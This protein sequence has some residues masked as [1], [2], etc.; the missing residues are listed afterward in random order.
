[1]CVLSGYDDSFTILTTVECLDAASMQ[2]TTQTA[3]MIT[4]R[5]SPGAA[6]VDRTIYAVGGFTT[7]M[8]GRIASMESLDMSNPA[9]VWV[10]RPAMT[11]A[12]N[13]LA[14]ASAGAKLY[15]V[16]GSAD[17]VGGGSGATDV[18]EIFDT[19]TE[20]WTTGSPMP[21]GRA[22]LAAVIVGNTLLAIGGQNGP[23]IL[24]TVDAYDI[25]AGSWSTGVPMDTTRMDFAA[26]ALVPTQIVGTVWTLGRNQYGQL[27]D[28]STSHRQSL[29]QVASLGDDNAAVVCGDYWTVVLKR[30]GRVFTFGQNDNGQLGDGSM[31]T[32]TS[33]VQASL[34]AGAEVTQLHAGYYHVLALRQDGTVLHWGDGTYGQAGDGGTSGAPTPHQIAALGSDNALV[35]GT[36]FTC[37][38]LKADGALWAWGYNQA[39]QLAD[40]T[41]THHRPTPAQIASVSTDNAFVTG[42]SHHVL[43]LKADGALMGWGYNDRGQLGNGNTDDQHSPIAIFV[44]G[45]PVTQVSAG[46]KQSYATAADGTVYAWGNN[47]NYAL[48]D[49]TTTDRHSPVIVSGYQ[50]DPAAQLAGNVGLHML[51]LQPDGTAVGWG[52]NDYG[53]VGTGG[54]SDVQT[55][56]DSTA[57]GQGIVTIAPGYQHTAVI[58]RSSHLSS[59]SPAPQVFAVASYITAEHDAWLQSQPAIGSD[60]WTVCYNSA[61]DCTN[62]PSCFHSPC[63]QYSET[64]A[65]ARNEIT[66]CGDS[67]G[68][69]AGCTLG[70]HIFGGYVR[71]QALSFFRFGSLFSVY[72]SRVFVYCA[73]CSPSSCALAG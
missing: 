5:T 59:P 18:L 14:V 12:R 21:T 3:E 6:V 9:A 63:D 24:D 37:L 39:G 36:Y 56:Q 43:L 67:S 70:A 25:E 11:T 64:V 41:T 35:S 27:G 46:F 51:V 15:V 47:E 16:G 26:V 42:G 30:D 49:G 72:S 23:S 66:D 7:T 60:G 17:H 4:A 58:K 20:T 71:Q 33:P 38:V 50:A 45:A 73:V 28:G 52:R 2:W 48:G 40:G 32:R 29:A 62:E 68:N 31:S 8:R 69:N 22:A 61:T 34:P 55:A 53:Q 54:T 65:I 57:L 13:R 44:P 1:M 19:S 10:E